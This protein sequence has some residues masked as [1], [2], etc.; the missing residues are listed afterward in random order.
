MELDSVIDLRSGALELY[1]IAWPPTGVD[2]VTYGLA[3]V[4]RKR[5][6][7]GGGVLL[8]L[9]ESLTSTAALLDLCTGQADAIVGAFH[10][11][12][13]P[14]VSN[15]NGLQPLDFLVTVVVVDVA[16]DALSYMVPMSQVSEEEDVG[17]VGFGEDLD[18][19]PNSGLLLSRVATW[20]NELTDQRAV[21][22][23]AEEGVE[24]ADLDGQPMEEEQ[25]EPGMQTPKAT[26]AKLTPK[27]KESKPKRVTTASL[28]EQMR[29]LLEV[30]PALTQQVEAMRVEQEALKRSVEEGQDR[31]APRPS[32]L[33]ISAPLASVAKMLGQPPR[34][35]AAARLAVPMSPAP[36][37]PLG[38]QEI[39]EEKSPMAGDPLSH[40]VLEQ[41]KA[42]TA[43]VAHLQQGGDPL[44]D[45]HGTSSGSSLGTRGSVG[46]EKLQRELAMRSGGFFLAVLQNAA[47]RLKPASKMPETVDALAQTDFSMVQYLER[48]GGYGGSKELGLIQY[49]LA[50]ICDALVHG[51][52]EGAKEHLALLMVGVEQA[53]MDHGRWELAYRLMLLDE[54]PSQLWSYRQAGYD[55]KLRAFAPLCPQRWTT[56]ALAYSKEIDYIHQ[57]RSEMTHQPK[58][59]PQG[60]SEPKAAP[61]KPGK[62]SPKGKG[63]AKPQEET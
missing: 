26:A 52:S 44:L 8:A 37:P 4:V 49:A 18:V 59:N 1:R 24:V 14:A 31:P 38:I 3:L 11:F 13:I 60:L 55:P 50:H 63:P 19:L 20:L 5:H 17:I 27:A 7:A 15:Q 39:A 9:P 23:S 53:C 48:F 42:L 22:Y 40:A 57:K 32:Q 43:L 61:K 51:D 10:Y 6:G 16:L 46:R 25:E 28:A 2:E 56:T 36:D 35:K 30:V 62:G 58:G 45:G 34:T 12:D 21:F 47:R 29:T 54:P 41:S 33:P